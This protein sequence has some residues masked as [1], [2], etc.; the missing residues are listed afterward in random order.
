MVSRDEARPLEITEVR[1]QEDGQLNVFAREIMEQEPASETPAI[2]Q[3]PRVIYNPAPKYPPEAHA[4][5]NPPR[6]SGRFRIVFSASGTVQDVEIVQSTGYTA[7]DQSA[8]NT[9]RQWK[10]E[11]H[12]GE[13]KVL[14]PIT[15]EP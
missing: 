15:F 10:S 8:V 12:D 13:W 2:R 9:L 5:K 11:P 6:G 3:T 14:I 1:R 4:S 7:L